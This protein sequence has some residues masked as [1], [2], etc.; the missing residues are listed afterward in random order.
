M[1]NKHTQTHANNTQ[2]PAPLQ[3][4]CPRK[5][6]L[7]VKTAISS[8]ALSTMEVLPWSDRMRPP[9]RAHVWQKTIRHPPV[10][11]PVASER[12]A[13]ASGRTQTQVKVFTS[14]RP[15]HP[16]L[17]CSQARHT[18]SVQLEST[19]SVTGRMYS[20]NWWSVIRNLQLTG[21]VSRTVFFTK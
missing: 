8:T 19:W 12:R 7:A 16:L 18:W 3:S 15:S 1:S 17:F 21:C 5:P 6:A 13:P 14:G 4:L 9:R 11:S 10:V 20:V 2:T